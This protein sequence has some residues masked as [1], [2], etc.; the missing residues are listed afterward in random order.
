MSAGTGIGSYIPFP[1]NGIV[2]VI[3]TQLDNWSRA[4]E[5]LKPVSILQNWLQPS[6]ATK[7]P[8]SQPSPIY[9]AP[10]PH[11][12]LLRVHIEGDIFLQLKP[13]STLQFLQPIWL[14]LSHC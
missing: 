3:L 12:G 14:K 11:T 4:P 2:D 1:H 5:H 13:V 10:L 8:S 9:I 6:P 7:F